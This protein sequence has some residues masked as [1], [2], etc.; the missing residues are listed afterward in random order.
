MFCPQDVIQYS[1]QH[2]LD[3]WLL[4]MNIQ[5]LGSDLLGMSDSISLQQQM[6]NLVE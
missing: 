4:C 6:G 2:I 3:V 5:N 1:T